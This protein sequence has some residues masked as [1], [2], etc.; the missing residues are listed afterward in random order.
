LSDLGGIAAM[1]ER[2]VHETTEDERYTGRTAA[3]KRLDRWCADPAVRVIGVTG[4]GGLGKTSLIGHWLKRKQG[5]RGRPFA[6]LFFWSFYADREVVRVAKA[7]VAFMTDAL[8]VS[9]PPANTEPGDTA[10]AMLLAREVLLV[11]DGLEVLQERPDQTG[12]GAFL[13]QDLNDLLDGACRQASDSLVVLTSRFPFPDLTR[14]LGDGFPGAGPGVPL[15]VRG[16]R[17]CGR[18]CGRTRGGQPPIRG[19]SIGPASV[20]LDAGGTGERRSHAAG[21]PGV[22]RGTC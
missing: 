2:W 22:R 7:Y 4:M 6:G 3:L 13:A 18:V 15:A 14:Y 21:G 20:R 12:Y 16:R 19:P 5:A 1:A 9:A 10:L 8:R 17:R 11:L